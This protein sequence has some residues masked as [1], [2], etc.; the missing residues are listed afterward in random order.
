MSVQVYDAYWHAFNTVRGM[1]PVQTREGNDAFNAV[2]QRL[3]DEHGAN[4][5]VSC[6][7]CRQLRLTADLEQESLIP[8]SFE[9]V[10]LTLACVH[11][12]ENVMPLDTPSC[13]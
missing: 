3:V 10:I 1:A 4:L 7:T 6:F 8:H 13:R 12:L 5:P 11:V 9:T 2:L